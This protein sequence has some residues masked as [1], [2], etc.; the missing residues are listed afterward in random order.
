MLCLI[1]KD[2]T[3]FNVIRPYSYSHSI[4]NILSVGDALYE[5]NA[6]IKY[7]KYINKKHTYPTYIKTIKY[8][9]NPTVVD[10]IHE[11]TSL[12]FN[13]EYHLNYKL[14]LDIVM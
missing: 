13:I 2:I 1:W 6:L 14:N 11:T 5:K 9:D 10:L 3:F 12:L 4:N 8:K 7:G